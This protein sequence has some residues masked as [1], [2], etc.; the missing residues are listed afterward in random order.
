MPEAA[1]E[2]IAEVQQMVQRLWLE[3][4]TA[5]GVYLNDALP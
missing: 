4:K 5:E 3:V 2:S 1:S